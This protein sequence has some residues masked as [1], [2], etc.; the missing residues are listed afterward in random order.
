MPELC[1]AAST[2]DTPA[3]G[4]TDRNAA[5]APATCGAAIEVPLADPNPP[6]T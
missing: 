3:A 1:S 5:H 4:T 6:G 2:D